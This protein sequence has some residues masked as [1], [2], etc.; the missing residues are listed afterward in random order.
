[1][2]SLAGEK[3][4]IIILQGLQTS[5]AINQSIPTIKPSELPMSGGT[6]PCRISNLS[7]SRDRLLQSF[8]DKTQPGFLML[9]LFQS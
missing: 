4:Y 7:L 8:M 9:F 6:Q 2:L 5:E 1:M 3:T